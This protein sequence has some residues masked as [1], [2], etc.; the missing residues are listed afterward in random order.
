MTT[1]KV[2]ITSIVMVTVAVSMLLSG[3]SYAHG[4]PEPKPVRIEG[5]VTTKDSKPVAGRQ[6]V[7]WC[8]D[9][10]HLGGTGNTDKSGHYTIRTD[11]EHCPLG[12]QLSAVVYKLSDPSSIEGIGFATVKKCT[13]A[14][15]VLNNDVVNVPEFGAVG[16]AAAF[17]TAGGALVLA[18]RN[19]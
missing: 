8:G 15:I 5:R 4:M 17:I 13:T 14:N 1:K 6:V 19:S 16:A 7:A 12:S 2:F 10:N 3:V 11:T 18:R 9:I